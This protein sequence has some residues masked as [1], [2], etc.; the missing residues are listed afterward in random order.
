M[1]SIFY[2]ETTTVTKIYCWIGPI[3][4]LLRLNLRMSSILQAFGPAAPLPPNA[5]GADAM[6]DAAW[7]RGTRW[8]RGGAGA[9]APRAPPGPADH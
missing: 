6:L 2:I 5:R 9:Q 7:R 3:L 4:L 8:G 1:S